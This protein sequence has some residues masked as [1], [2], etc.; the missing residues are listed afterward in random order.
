MEGKLTGEL[1][2]GSGGIVRWEKLLVLQLF[3][4]VIECNKV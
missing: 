3:C 1:Q 4:A 2:L